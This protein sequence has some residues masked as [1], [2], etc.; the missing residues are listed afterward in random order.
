MLVVVVAVVVVVDVAVVVGKW[1]AEFFAGIKVNQARIKYGSKEASLEAATTCRSIRQ[2]AILLV[3]KG[4][5]KPG[6]LFYFILLYFTF[7][8]K[9]DFF[10]RRVFVSGKRRRTPS[11]KNKL[12]FSLAH[13]RARAFAASNDPYLTTKNLFKGKKS[14]RNLRDGD[15]NLISKLF[16]FRE[17]KKDEGRSL[18]SH[19]KQI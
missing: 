16:L 7:P 17:Q 12:F 11:A 5:E 1:L 8:T 15:Q 4:N 3:F 14:N 19:L 9:P 2:S 10:V 18:K 13:V 6:F